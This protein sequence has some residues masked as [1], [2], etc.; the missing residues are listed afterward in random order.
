MLTSYEFYF[1]VKRLHL[2]VNLVKFMTMFTPRCHTSRHL[3]TTTLE[4]NVSVTMTNVCICLYL[5][6]IDLS[7]VCD[8]HVKGLSTSVQHLDLFVFTFRGRGPLITRVYYFVI[9]LLTLQ[10][11]PFLSLRDPLITCVFTFLEFCLMANLCDYFVFCIRA[12][13]P[14]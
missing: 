13:P 1:E 5:E 14:K 12:S 9:T 11:T 4:D 6:A 3:V 2:L 7:T 10:D 8:D